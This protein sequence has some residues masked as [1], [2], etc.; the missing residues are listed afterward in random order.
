MVK[1]RRFSRVDE[2]FTGVAHCVRTTESII[3][4]GFYVSSLGFK[5]ESPSDFANCCLGPFNQ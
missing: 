4:A 3:D 2:G 1:V 5:R